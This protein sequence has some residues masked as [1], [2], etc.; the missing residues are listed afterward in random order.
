MLAFLCYSYVLLLFCGPLLCKASCVTPCP[1]F[2]PWACA[3]LAF[4]CY[5]PFLVFLWACAL[6]AV[7]FVR[8]CR[9][10]F[11]VLPPAACFPV[12][13]CRVSF[14]VLPLVLDFLSGPV[15]C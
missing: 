14:F 2:P 9:V 7:C 4:L 8:L 11:L 6:L 12:G 15:L 10:S 13:L 3:L 1:A 5:S